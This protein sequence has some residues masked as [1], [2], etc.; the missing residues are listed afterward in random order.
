MVTAVPHGSR[1]RP[2]HPR[3]W[4]ILSAGV[5][6]A[7]AVVGTASAGTALATSSAAPTP[8]SQATIKLIPATSTAT[9]TARTGFVTRS[10]SRLLL[11]G[12]TFRFAGA[13]EY[14]LGLDDNIRDAGGNPTY[15]TKA[16]IDDALS[17][18]VATGA[19]VIRSHT[20]GISVGCPVCLE[21]TPGV[22]DDKALA[23][24][25]YAIYR[26]ARLG[27]KLMIP[28]TDQWRFY[29]GGESTFTGWAGYPNS[30]D[31]NA[32]A[33]NN[34]AQRQAESYFYTD[35]SVVSAFRVYVG[36][37]LN[38]VNPYTGLA[39]KNDPTIMAWETG[40]EIW[41]AQPS[42]TQSLAS[43]IKHT[44]GA[45]QL[46]AD[47]SAASGMSVADAAV[48]AP[49]VDILGGHFYPVDTAWMQRDAATAAAHQKAYV[50]GEF[51]WTDA[52]A[53][54]ALIATVQAD[55]NIAGDLYWTLMPHLENGSPEPHDDGF[56][57]Y[58]P[59]QDA[60]AAELLAALTKHARWMSASR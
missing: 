45:K 47:G 28:L 31:Q 30:T 52:S 5:A 21:P 11:N 17:S 49:D 19:T 46:V 44:V 32:N 50:V 48:D 7:V 29:H 59:A 18:A 4:A 35:P 43:F 54:A 10:G 39:Y 23:S 22:F 8:A 42:W 3:R 15:P 6:L 2:R 53:T 12:S 9:T 51:D 25:D 13:N 20:L 60:A 34:S 57:M 38:H 24:A 36:H 33:A 37:L 14:Y 26:A 41:T 55:P 27:L 16:R 58:S 1:R 40:N 56:T